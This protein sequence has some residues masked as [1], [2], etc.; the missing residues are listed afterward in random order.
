MLQCKCGTKT[1][2]LRYKNGIKQCDKCS[3]QNLSGTFLRRLEGEALY[4]KRD[5]LQPSDPNFKDVYGE[6]R[7]TTT[8]ARSKKAR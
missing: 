6:G 4:Y 8:K 3:P 5:I 2:K 7:N 1:N